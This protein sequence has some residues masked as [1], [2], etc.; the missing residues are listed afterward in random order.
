L[1]VGR[2][3]FHIYFHPAAFGGAADFWVVVDGGNYRVGAAIALIQVKLW[4]CEVAL[5]VTDVGRSIFLKVFLLGGD[6]VERVDVTELFLGID[7]ELTW[8]WTQGVLWIHEV[9]KEYLLSGK[10]VL[11][12]ASAGRSSLDYWYPFLKTFR[13]ALVWFKVLFAEYY[14]WW[15]MKFVLRSESQ[16]IV[17]SINFFFFF[18]LLDRLR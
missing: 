12:G 7:H 9:S 10:T 13:V 17:F 14:V 5:Q 8:L 4:A 15:I 3:V 18:A 2:G 11:I 16:R 6:G 1:E